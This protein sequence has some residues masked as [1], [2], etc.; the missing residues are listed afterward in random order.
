MKVQVQIFL[1]LLLLHTCLHS[2]RITNVIFCMFVFLW[3]ENVLNSEPKVEI[4]FN[5]L[6]LK[7]HFY[8]G[9]DKLMIIMMIMI[10]LLQNSYLLKDFKT[11]K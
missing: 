1:Q 6:P 9:V 3:T 11:Q 4:L 10:C 7:Y 5:N 2:I 8:I